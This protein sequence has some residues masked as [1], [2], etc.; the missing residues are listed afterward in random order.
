[1]VARLSWKHQLTA[2]MITGER[3]IHDHRDETFLGQANMAVPQIVITSVPPGEAP[4][5]VRSEW[6]GLELP[7]A[8][9]TSAKECRLTAGVLTGPRSFI[10]TL[11]ALITGKL[12]KEV[13][14]RVPVI[15]A[16]D[17]LSSKSPAAADWWRKHT[18][19]LVR[20]GGYFIFHEHCAKI[21]DSA[22]GA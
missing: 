12:T 21:V 22:R 18:P 17:V 9:G 10:A 2:A 20:S 11:F 8:D 6:V 16:V 4:V 15:A 13:G 14:F 19:H 3:I 1:M 7:L 5:W